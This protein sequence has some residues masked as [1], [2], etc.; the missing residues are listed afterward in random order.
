P[1]RLT[2]SA[3][4]K[5]PR[6]SVPFSPSTVQIAAPR[7]FIFRIEARIRWPDW[8]ICSES[9]GNPPKITKLP[10]CIVYILLPAATGAVHGVLARTHA[11]LERARGA[12]AVQLLAPMLRPG[13][14]TR[15]DEIAVRAVLAEAW[16]LQDDLAQA[17]ATLGRPPDT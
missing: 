8:R 15:E 2:R 12:D 9:H 5:W 4:S 1:T 3:S 17:A 6:P 10:G 16:L 13:S 14:V 11:T 7:T